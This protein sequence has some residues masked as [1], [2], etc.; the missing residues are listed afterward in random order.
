MAEIDAK[1]LKEMLDRG[2]AIRNRYFDDE[3]DPVSALRQGASEQAIKA[4]ENQLGLRLPDSYRLFLS[5]SNGWDFV[6]AHVS[7]MSCQ[8]IANAY[9]N[10]TFAQWYRDVWLEELEYPEHTLIIGTSD[11]TPAKYL[12]VLPDPSESES[13]DTDWQIMYVSDDNEFYYDDFVAYLKQ[14][15][16]T[17]RQL[18]GD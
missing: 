18:V 7:L 8:E 10:N 11:I 12:L 4:L 2:V 6:D 1:R 9:K 17:Y 15:E 14:S 3:D 13:K 5:L 16:Q